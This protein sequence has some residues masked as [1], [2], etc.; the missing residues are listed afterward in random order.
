M[1]RGIGTGLHGIFAALADRV[2]AVE[3]WRQSCQRIRSQVLANSTLFASPQE[4]ERFA[5]LLLGS[6]SISSANKEAVA[7]QIAANQLAQW[8]AERFH[9]VFSAELDFWGW[10]FGSAAL[11]AGIWLH[12]AAGEVCFQSGDEELLAQI[13]RLENRDERIVLLQLATHPENAAGQKR[14]VVHAALDEEL[15]QAKDSPVAAYLAAERSR[16]AERIKPLR[17]AVEL[18]PDYGCAWHD[19]AS[20]LPDDAAEK[21]QAWQA[22]R[23]Y[24]TAHL[25]QAQQQG[26]TADDS[27]YRALFEAQHA[28]REQ[29]AALATLNDWNNSLD[30]SAIAA[31]RLNIASAYAQVAQPSDALRQLRLAALK[32]NPGQTEQIRHLAARLFEPAPLAVATFFLAALYPCSQASSD[33]AQVALWL[34]SMNQAPAAHT[35]SALAAQDGSLSPD[36]TNDLAYDLLTPGTVEPACLAL[37]ADLAVRAFSALPSNSTCAETLLCAALLNEQAVSPALRQEGLARLLAADAAAKGDIFQLAGLL[38]DAR[39]FTAT[40]TL[41]TWLAESED[42]LRN[43]P[44]AQ[45]LNARLNG[46]ALPPS[47][48]TEKL[49]EALNQIE[50]ELAK[51]REWAEQHREDGA[52]LAKQVNRFVIN[53]TSLGWQNSFSVSSVT[54]STPYAASSPTA[55]PARRR[56]FS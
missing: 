7:S 29:A 35:L 13:R 3:D 12:L 33:L 53:K 18:Q 27:I 44:A 8:Q 24:A 2:G 17:R 15:A 43:S 49:D 16:G 19:L 46:L 48:L 6:Q 47:P 51:A 23:D 56:R 20:A 54:P 25:Q 10:L 55:A 39:R 42:A 37:A 28:L 40:A 36:W 32:A 41:N 26:V 50:A 4:A 30:S 14:S 5:W 9:K 34:F 45:W 11:A 22:T 1:L 31:Q 52:K 38:F 21:H